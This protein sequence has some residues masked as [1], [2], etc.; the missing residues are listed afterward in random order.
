MSKKN[1]RRLSIE[2]TYVNSRKILFIKYYK[3]DEIVKTMYEV[4]NLAKSIK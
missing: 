4:L 1:L 3:S 2:D